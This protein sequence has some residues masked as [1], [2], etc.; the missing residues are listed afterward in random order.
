MIFIGFPVK[1]NAAK[2]EIN[3]KYHTQQEIIDY[4]N[5]T[6][7]FSNTVITY[8][9]DPVFTA[10]YNAGK[11]SQNV[12]DRALVTMNQIRYI[13][14]IEP[15]KIDSSYNEQCQIGCLVNAVN[16]TMTHYPE[17]PSD[18]SQDLFNKNACGKSNLGS[19]Y[20]T[21]ESA[22]IDGWM[23]DGDSSNIDRVGHRRWVLNPSMGKVGF[24]YVNG[25]SAMYAF[26][27]SNSSTIYH[28]V[29]W[30]A[31]N[32]PCEIFSKYYPWSVSVNANDSTIVKLTRTNDGKVWKFYYG[33]KDGYFNIDRGGYG[34]RSCIIFRP[35]DIEYN[36]GDRY[37]VEITGTASPI[38]YSVNFF[39][40]KKIIN[41]GDVNADGQIN[42]TDALLTLQHSIGQIILTDDKFTCGD[43]TKDNQI[44]SL[45]ALEILQ[46][47]IG[48]IS[49]F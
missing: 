44:N 13:A 7:G 4:I 35:L 20:R 17:K 29:A 23:E 45:D 42:S 27:N 6:G 12:L 40:Y 49:N 1:T 25:H 33:C 24:G 28:G 21:L 2:D 15:V 31:A 11:L 5:A 46:Y 10:P 19:G 14:G 22:I 9:K 43:V 48:Q 16:R 36:P 47:S 37:N 32:T 30:P 39:S 26:D 18:M 8:E 3:V 34:E 38:T 41:Y